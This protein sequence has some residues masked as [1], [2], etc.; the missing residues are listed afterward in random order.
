[1]R[2]PRI[3][4]RVGGALLGYAA[5]LAL[6]LTQSRSGVVAGLLVLVLWLVL[7]DRRLEDG[8]RLA[9]L[10]VPALV[11]VGWAFTRPALVEVEALRDD[12]VA[13]GRVFA[14][15]AV[16]GAAL[17]VA[18]LWLVPVRRLVT[19]RRRAVRTALAVVA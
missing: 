12:R 4:V 15:L 13:D 11:V 9:L 10:A 19:E 18:G 7:S 1:M 3:A 2:D 14:V 8:L 6:L 5:V 16:T 17:A